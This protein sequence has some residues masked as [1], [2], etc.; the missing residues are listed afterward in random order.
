MK[1]KVCVVLS[2]EVVPLGL[3]EGFQRGLE[4]WASPPDSFTLW[5]VIF[6]L[7]K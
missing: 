5:K 3:Y 1:F 4:N 2:D 6:D 7:N